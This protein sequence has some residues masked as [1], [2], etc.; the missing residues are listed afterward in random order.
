MTTVNGRRIVTM[1]VELIDFFGDQSEADQAQGCGKLQGNGDF[2]G[3]LF[4]VDATDFSKIGAIDPTD[5]EADEEASDM[6]AKS[7]ARSSRRGRTPPT[8]PAAS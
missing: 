8:A 2:A 6:K 3:P 5:A 4:I 1:P 7:E